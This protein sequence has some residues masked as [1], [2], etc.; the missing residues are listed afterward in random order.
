MNKIYSIIVLIM[1]CSGCAQSTVHDQAKN[2]YGQTKKQVTEFID[3]QYADDVVVFMDT[4]AQQVLI[5]QEISTSPAWYRE[6]ININ[7]GGIPLYKVVDVIS[8]KHE[9]A[10]HFASDIDI[11]QPLFL[12]FTGAV[13]DALNAIST[14]SDYSFIIK[15][16]AISWSKY[17]TK[18]YAIGHIGGNYSYQI[19]SSA[20]DGQAGGGALASSNSQYQTTVSSSS[21]F[22]EIK[23]TLESILG[24]DQAS[25]VIMLKS[26][27][28]VTVKAT[29][30]ILDI[31]DEYMESVNDDLS[32][33]VELAI[34][35]IKFQGN[36]SSSSGIDWNLVRQSTNKLFFDGASI[37]S[38]SANS[39]ANVFG[40]SRETGTYATS[41]ILLSALSEQGTVKIV[42]EPTIL[43]QVNRVAEL[44]LGQKQT[45]I[46]ETTTTTDADGV[47]TSS[48]EPA[49]V[50]SG[51]TIYVVAN[52]D[53]EGRIYLQ[54]NSSNIDLL[55]IERKTVG[56]SAIESPSIHESKFSQTLILQEG[57]TI[58]A[59][60]LNESTES[61]LASSPIDSE[62]IPLYKKGS[63]LTEET[64]VLITPRIRR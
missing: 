31:V 49:T 61:S 22:D 42:T 34:Q 8:K 47:V 6:T 14:V 15:E 25:Q 1:L 13:I 60:R 5:A 9:L 41:N 24:N 11:N 30:S 28:A 46:S 35:V 38:S 16:N 40:V 64:I 53:D 50:T 45:Y 19:G 56:N 3:N 52:V 54:I 23:L 7:A 26:S 29:K 39:L 33:Q 20:G 27:S 57:Q 51:Y 58:V 62:S 2:E 48:I 44:H 37:S 55:G 17:K 63:N 32:V 10:V 43:T 36:E 18:R 4:P 12:N 21:V 59:N